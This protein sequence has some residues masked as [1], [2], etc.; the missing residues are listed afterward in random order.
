MHGCVSALSSQTEDIT[1]AFSFG[2]V[3]IS[4]RSR[5]RPRKKLRFHFM[6]RKQ[7]IKVSATPLKQAY[8]LHFKWIFTVCL[9]LMFN[10]FVWINSLCENEDHFQIYLF[11]CA[12]DERKCQN[13]YDGYENWLVKQM[14]CVDISIWFAWIDGN[15]MFNYVLWTNF[16]VFAPNEV[17][18]KS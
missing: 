18:E 2:I 11:E 17:I 8:I 6:F 9:F 5:M 12:K 15:V 16:F 7:Y 4:F 1:A 10:S 13:N 14:K 3:S